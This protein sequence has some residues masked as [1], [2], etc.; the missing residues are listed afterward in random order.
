MAR[1]T[2]QDDDFDIL[3]LDIGLE[4]DEAALGTEDDQDSVARAIYSTRKELFA[5]S[6]S[7]AANATTRSTR[8]WKPIT[9]KDTPAQAEGGGK[10]DTFSAM[11][12]FHERS[13]TPTD[14]GN[15]ASK[16][17]VGVVRMRFKLQPCNVQK[18]LIGLL[19]HCLSVLHERDKSACI[20]NK[21]MTLEAKKVSDFPRDFTD[22]YDEWGLWEEDITMFL[23]TIKDKGQRT[24]AAS[25]YFR[26]SSDPAA[27]FAKTLLKMAKQSQHK[28]SVSIEWKPCQYLD[29]TRDIIFFNL[30]F[31]DAV[32]LRDYIKSA[33]IR[34]KSR[35]IHRY[36]TEF[37]RKDWD[38]AFQDFEMVRDFVKNTPWRS[39]EEKTTIP[40]LH[41]LVWH[42]ECPREEVPFIYRILKVM[43]KNRS[44]HKLLGQNV[45]IMKN[46]GR[47]AP[48]S[49]KMELASYVHWHTAYQ[50]S[51]NH[52]VLR[53]LVNPDKRVELFRLVADGDGDAQESVITS[54]REILTKHKVDHLRLWQGMFQ[55]DDGSWKGFYSNGKGC[56]R[57]KGTATRWSGCPAAHLRFHLL[58]RGVTNDS[59]LNL[60]RRSFTPQAF[61]DALQATFK[62]GKVVSADDLK[63]AKRTAP[64]VDITQGMEMSEKREH[65]L[66]LQGRTP[67]LDPS[68]PE[69]LNFNEEQ[70]FK[71]LGTAGTNA[72]MYTSNQSVSLGGT[73]FKPRD[74]DDIVSQESPIFGS[75]DISKAEEN[76]DD[77]TEGAFIENMGAFGL[78]STNPPPPTERQEDSGND[79][80]LYRTQPGNLILSPAKVTRT[81]SLR[82]GFSTAISDSQH[83]EIEAMIQQWVDANGSDNIPAHLADL[84]MSH[85]QWIFCNY[86]LHGNEF[87]TSAQSPCRQSMCCPKTPTRHQPHPTSTSADIA[88]N[89]RYRKPD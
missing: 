35:L 88:S 62:D 66:E 83:K 5:S 41:K 72:S 20:L 58:K 54:V 50:M 26:C 48:P 36:P 6:L 22:F 64:W 37:P 67:L 19:A 31:C 33:L 57:H 53:G 15:I 78:G 68:N 10:D 39:R 86:T 29:T 24:F 51:I 71:S 74:T 81:A 8:M 63:D 40:A 70:F 9:P 43:E 75:S 27:L 77:N 25:F 21:K 47:D 45:K 42:L 28:G 52:V 11:T 89:K 3:P 16:P 82:S 4:D 13:P 49:L 80:E 44:I 7:K 85:S 65:V 14:G 73:A 1:D 12:V 76:T 32:G 23:N 79:M 56:E 60:I 84:A 2:T 59:A 46:V 87:A 55:N 18:T 61:R 30:P 34:E 38:Q 69:A 17:N